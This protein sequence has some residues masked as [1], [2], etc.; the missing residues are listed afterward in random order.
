MKL[1]D[2]TVCRLCKSGLSIEL[3]QLHY[4]DSQH[5]NVTYSSE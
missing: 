1:T 5:F 3:E 2:H 4:N